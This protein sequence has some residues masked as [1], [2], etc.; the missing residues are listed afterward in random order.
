MKRENKRELR[1]ERERGLQNGKSSKID[2]EIIYF[3]RT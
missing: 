1:R 2:M 3:A